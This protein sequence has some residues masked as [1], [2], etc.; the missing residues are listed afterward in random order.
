MPVFV[1]IAAPAFPAKATNPILRPAGVL[2]PSEGPES[3]RFQIAAGFDQLSAQVIKPGTISEVVCLSKPFTVIPMVVTRF[4]R[5][6][7]PG[8]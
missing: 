1:D 3:G 4:N 2:I 7:L 5:W 8:S 6:S